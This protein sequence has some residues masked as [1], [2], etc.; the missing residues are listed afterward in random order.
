MGRAVHPNG[1]VG[2]VGEHGGHGP[3]PVWPTR[4]AGPSG[5]QTYD[6]DV[7]QYVYLQ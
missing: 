5:P 3:V 2:R 6:M 7:Q 1:L 4:S